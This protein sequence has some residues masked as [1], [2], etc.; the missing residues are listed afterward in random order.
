ML[1]PVESR[2]AGP[3]SEQPL[4]TSSCKPSAIEF[5][6]SPDRL[7]A[8]TDAYQLAR[9]AV[10]DC[11]AVIAAATVRPVDDTIQRLDHLRTE[12]AL[13]AQE[14]N[15]AI[16]T[17]GQSHNSWVR[18]AAREEVQLEQLAAAEE[19]LWEEIL[20]LVLLARKR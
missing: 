4:A 14:Q 10:S 12:Q 16:A 20:M 6:C 9:S 7:L 18:A 11:I 5:E 13:L 15:A 2:P 17:Y 1:G 8:V 3:A 19:H